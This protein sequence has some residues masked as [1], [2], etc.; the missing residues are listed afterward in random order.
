MPRKSTGKQDNGSP[1]FDSEDLVESMILGVTSEG[2]CVYIHNFED[3]IRALEFLETLTVGFR[4]DILSG[5]IRRS[6]N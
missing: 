5:I 1:E 4:S 3:D 6:V 2:E